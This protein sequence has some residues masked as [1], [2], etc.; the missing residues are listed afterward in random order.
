MKTPAEA[1]LETAKVMLDRAT[2]ANAEVLKTAGAL[3]GKS[4]AEGGVLHTFGRAT[5]KSS[6]GKSLVAPVD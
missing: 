1:Y 6:V 5:V 4:I 3:V 2:A